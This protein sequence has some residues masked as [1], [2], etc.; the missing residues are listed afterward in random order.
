MIRDL[1]FTNLTLS[2]CHVTSQREHHQS[3]H[4]DLLE[5]TFESSSPGLERN[6]MC[7][8]SGLMDTDQMSSVF[9]I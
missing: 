1:S 9:L 7:N 6:T 4:L 2:D 5:I 3:T 8:V